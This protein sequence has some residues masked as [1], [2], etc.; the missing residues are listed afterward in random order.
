MTSLLLR[1][2]RVAKKQKT[3]HGLLTN[4]PCVGFGSSSCPETTEKNL[5]RGQGPLQVTVSLLFSTWSW[6]KHLL[7]G[8]DGLKDWDPRKLLPCSD[9]SLT[10]L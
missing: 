9:S 10:P 1:R 2:L 7:D 3:T 8:D 6:W 5:R 4:S